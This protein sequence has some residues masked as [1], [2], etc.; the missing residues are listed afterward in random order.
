[1]NSLQKVN[2]ELRAEADEAKRA[3]HG[4][5]PL[6]TPLMSTARAS[7]G[8]LV[9][10]VTAIVDYQLTHEEKVYLHSLAKGNDDMADQLRPNFFQR[11]FVDSDEDFGTWAQNVADSTNA[12][13]KTS[14]T[15]S[16][17][18][19][20]ETETESAKPSLPTQKESVKPLSAPLTTERS[21]PER[22]IATRSA[23]ANLMSGALTSSPQPPDHI[24]PSELLVQLARAA[25]LDRVRDLTFR[26]WEESI[27]WYSVLQGSWWKSP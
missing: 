5:R 23:D 6:M 20:M 22:S 3:A 24:T 2:E 27:Q 17:D 4:T 10:L 14:K 15:I 19:S 1:M 8:T 7:Q 11:I 25:P 9:K 12:L 26:L 18:K 16:P 21:T 13:L